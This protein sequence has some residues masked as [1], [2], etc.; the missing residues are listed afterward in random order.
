[1]TFDSTDLEQCPLFLQDENSGRYYDSF[2]EA[3]RKPFKHD[4]REATTAKTVEEEMGNSW[5]QMNRPSPTVHPSEYLEADGGSA[6]TESSES[7]DS[8]QS[9]T[10]NDEEE[11]SYYA[12]RML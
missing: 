7:L 10:P 11:I 1:M 3:P 5:E 6:V 9:S 12:V 8:T 4:I 2:A